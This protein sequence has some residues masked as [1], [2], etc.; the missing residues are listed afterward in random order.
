MIR[1]IKLNDRTIEYNLQY[2]NVKNINLRIKSD[3][4]VNVSAGKWVSQ[5]TIDAFVTSKADFI[6]GALDKYENA[7]KIPMRQYFGEDEYAAL[8][9]VCAKTHIR[10]SGNSA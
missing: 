3:G 4:S 8:Y 1:K 2:K 6:L 7:K 10:I 9:S 5:N